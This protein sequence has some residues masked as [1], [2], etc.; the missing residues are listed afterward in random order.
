LGDWCILVSFNPYLAEF[1]FSLEENGWMEDVGK[2][3]VIKIGRVMGKGTSVLSSCL[4]RKNK[5]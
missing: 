5:E 2:C 4:K 1:E 3:V